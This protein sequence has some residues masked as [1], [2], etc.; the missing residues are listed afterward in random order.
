MA[1]ERIRDY[2]AVMI[3]SPEAT[4]EE[5][6][7]T[8]ERVDAL[9]TRHSGVIAEREPWGLKRL[10]YPIKN[11]TEGNYILT[12]FSLDANGVAEL[13]RSLA[14]SE[15]IMRFLVTRTEL[16]KPAPDDEPDETEAAGDADSP[17]EDTDSPAG[18]TD[19]PAEDTDS[20]AGDTDSPA[21][22]TDSPAGDAASASS[23]DAEGKVT[24]NDDE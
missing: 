20:P 14:A 22:D 19:S 8:V 15:D 12:R 10:A 13:N 6:A 23:D 17:A 3:L 24:S 16:A 7:S 2:E 9:I 11:F 1:A 18:D 5:V 4:E 21:E